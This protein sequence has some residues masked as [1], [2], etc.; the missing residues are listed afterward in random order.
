MMVASEEKLKKEGKKSRGT[1]Y[2]VMKEEK[3]VV[4]KRSE[5][6]GEPLRSEV[7]R[8]RTT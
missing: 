8:R 3:E 7:D 6:R 5:E 1:P 2:C 4:G